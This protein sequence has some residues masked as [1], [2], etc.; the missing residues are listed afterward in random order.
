MA[1]CVSVSPDSFSAQDQA[2]DPNSP[3][4]MSPS[5]Q[6]PFYRAKISL[7]RVA[8]HDVP[9]GFTIA[10]GMPVT[11]DIKVGRRTVLKY[12]LGQALPITQ[13]GMREP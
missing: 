12:L 9:D 6:E 4:A 1:R 13:E 8:L 2:R 3:R 11:A 7:D 10:P 5:G